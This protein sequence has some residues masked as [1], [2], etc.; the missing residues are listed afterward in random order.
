MTLAH[1]IYSCAQSVLE[2]PRPEVVR[3][4]RTDVDGVPTQYL[5]AGAGPPLVLLHGHEHS[6][7]GWRWVIPALAR[8]HRSWW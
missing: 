6:A 2:A 3:D 5:D 7:A 4:L 1:T 8:T